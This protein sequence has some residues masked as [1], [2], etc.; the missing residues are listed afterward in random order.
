MTDKL[1][2]PQLTRHEG[3]PM[4]KG[5]AFAYQDHLGFWTIGVGRLIDKRKG[6]GLTAEEC[7]YLLAN[8]VGRFEAGLSA[9]IPW[10][11]TLDPVR[12]RVLL[13]M[14][15]NLGVEGL[16]GFR[17]TL[18]FIKAGRYREA[19]AAMLESKWATQVGARAITLS[20]M[21][22]TGKDPDWLK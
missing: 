8:D 6:G 20:K 21:M 14:A 4:E 16:L 13:D 11:I 12:R 1:I 9:A 22:E 5:R 18:S 2:F 10:W 15:F 3:R 7:D 19:A 17:R